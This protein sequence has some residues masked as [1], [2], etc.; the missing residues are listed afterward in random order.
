MTLVEI[1]T[2]ARSAGRRR[3]PWHRIQITAGCWLWTGPVHKGYGKSSGTTA[4]RHVWLALG[5]TIARGLE[6]DHLCRVP[7]CVN[8]DHLEPV[9][10]AENARRRSLAQV[11]CINGHDYTP[12]NTYI[13]PDG[14]RDCRTCIRARVAKY[15]RTHRIGAAA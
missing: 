12:E 11:T 2:P 10:R 9:T 5:R 1:P 6:L 3:V 4:H 14:H 8:P 13:K 7:L 15:A